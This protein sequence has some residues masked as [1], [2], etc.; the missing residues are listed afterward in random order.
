MGSLVPGQADPLILIL[1]EMVLR[2]SSSPNVRLQ[3]LNLLGVFSTHSNIHHTIPLAPSWSIV[4]PLVS[5]LVSSGKAVRC[6]NWGSASFLSMCSTLRFALGKALWVS[7]SLIN[8][9]R[10]LG[11]IVHS[12]QQQQLQEMVESLR[13]AAMSCILAVLDA[14]EDRFERIAHM[15]RQLQCWGEVR[16]QVAA[17]G[18]CDP[19]LQEYIR[20]LGN[21]VTTV[22]PVRGSALFLDGGQQ[23]NSTI[24]CLEQRF[25]TMRLQEYIQA[26][27]T[28]S[29]ASSKGGL[30]FEE[31][32]QCIAVIPCDVQGHNFSLFRA[33]VQVLKQ[34]SGVAWPLMPIPEGLLSDLAQLVSG[35]RPA[36]SLGWVGM[37]EAR[38]GEGTGLYHVRDL[39]R[40]VVALLGTF[41]AHGCC[42]NP[43]CTN[44]SGMGEMGL[45][46]GSKGATGVCS[47]C[48]MVCY[49]SRK[50]QRA[51]WDA[52]RG[53]CCAYAKATNLGS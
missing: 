13:W 5:T 44:M 39:R 12:Q 35:Q 36:S 47:G 42:N 30:V 40:N 27:N 28:I 33:L 24:Y 46:M 31:V 1:V 2:T 53:W 18:S 32:Y 3:A 11:S 38:R 26:I 41:Y 15:T 20:L 21:A 4:L 23:L 50:C 43:R 7:S 37:Q 14:Y 25:G 22:S 45:V 34:S 52:H 49:C 6:S 19:E 29:F 17:A 16:Q 8:Y 48:N 10:G 51:A 9:A